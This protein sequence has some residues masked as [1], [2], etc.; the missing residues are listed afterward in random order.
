MLVLKMFPATSVC[1]FPGSFA[2]AFANR[3]AIRFAFSSWS[4]FPKKKK[5][6]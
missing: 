5:K 1:S 3:R 6:K 2:T 4:S